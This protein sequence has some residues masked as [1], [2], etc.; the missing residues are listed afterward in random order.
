LATADSNGNRTDDYSVYL[1]NGNGTFQGAAP[2]ALEGAGASTAI[3]TG[4][5]AGDGRTDLAIARTS[6]DDVQVRLSK[7]AGTS[8]A[9][10][11]TN[12]VRRETPLVADPNGDGTDD[13]LVVNAAGNILYRR[14]IPGH[15]GSFDPPITINP[16]FPS[17]DIAWIPN[18]DQGPV[19]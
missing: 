16:G 12:L 7:G 8:S 13:V 5:F 6:P 4:D 2:I 10:A 14:G 1:G 11:A 19:L 18:T 15:P 17:R 9:P 3:V